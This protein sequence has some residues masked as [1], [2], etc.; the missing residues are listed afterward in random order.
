[1]LFD[2][3]I[4]NTDRHQDNWGFIFMVPERDRPA[5]CQ[6]APL[7]DNGTSLGHERFVSRIAGWRDADVDR[8]IGRGTHHMGK[9]RLG[10]FSS[11]KH[12][13]MVNH[14]VHVWPDTCAIL[15]ERLHLLERGLLP[16]LDDLVELGGEVPFSVGR[17]SFV[18]RLLSRR[19]TLL[20]AIIR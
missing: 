20:Q 12:A 3:I 17:A 13:D 8:Y 6:I 18:H 1:L 15:V 4:G 2:A 7:F 9:T 11:A 19:L 16:L 10:G 14:A 5:I